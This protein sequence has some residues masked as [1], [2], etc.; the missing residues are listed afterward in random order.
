[1]LL[2]KN[3]IYGE[4]YMNNYTKDLIEEFCG[5]AARPFIHHSLRFKAGLRDILNKKLLEAASEKGYI[6]DLMANNIYYV[7]VWNE[8][9]EMLERWFSTQSIPEQTMEFEDEMCQIEERYKVSYDDNSIKSYKNGRALSS[10]DLDLIRQYSS[11]IPMTTQVDQLEWD[12]MYYNTRNNIMYNLIRVM[13]MNRDYS[14]Q[15]Y[16]VN[17]TDVSAKLMKHVATYTNLCLGKLKIS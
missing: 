1:L 2:S 17:P 4:D 11:I 13:I 5:T 16:Q 10:D 12:Y 8:E 7:N 6:N 3:I 14:I 15:F 9:K